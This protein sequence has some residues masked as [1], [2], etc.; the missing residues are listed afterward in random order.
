M[1]KI[2][3]ICISKVHSFSCFC[4]PFDVTVIA[5]SVIVRSSLFPQRLWISCSDTLSFD[6]FVVYGCTK[7]IVT[8]W[9][10]WEKTCCFHYKNRVKGITPWINS[11]VI[12]KKNFSLGK[13][14]LPCNQQVSNG[15]CQ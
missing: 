6:E 11:G 10:M 4:C 14:M 9:R 13:E 5:I 2:C 15:Q 8:K 3:I 1:V 7:F 12:T